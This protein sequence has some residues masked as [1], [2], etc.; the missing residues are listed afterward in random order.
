MNIQ[1]YITQ[2]LQQI[3]AGIENANL[4]EN[5]RHFMLKRHEPIKF[6]LMVVN[7]SIGGGKVQA[8]VFGIGGKVDGS[9]TKD[10]ISKISFRVEHRHNVK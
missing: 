10:Q 3:D 7:K 8:T 2:T 6:D 1:E 9:I 5:S 4:K